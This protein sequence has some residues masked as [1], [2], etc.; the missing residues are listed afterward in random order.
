MW[1]RDSI[2]A[3]RRKQVEE[4]FAEASREELI[5]RII[6]LETEMYPFA[7]VLGSLNEASWRGTDASSKLFPSLSDDGKFQAYQ[8]KEDSP[9]DKGGTITLEA[10]A[11]DKLHEVDYYTEESLRIV[12]GE[13]LDDMFE[14]IGVHEQAPGAYVGCGS[15]TMGDVRSLRRVLYGKTE[16]KKPSPALPLTLP[17]RERAEIKQLNKQLQRAVRVI[18]DKDHMIHLMSEMLGPIGKQ[19]FDQWQKEGLVMMHCDW[20]PEGINTRGEARAQL[21]LDI[22]AAAKDPS[23]KPIDFSY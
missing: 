17:L 1:N 8:S 4:Q 16:E 22:D 14:I 6:A 2:A 12:N 19:A 20:G 11:E 5:D 3:D 21:Y 9:N 7:Y 18:K 15:I 13:Q 23:A 10:I